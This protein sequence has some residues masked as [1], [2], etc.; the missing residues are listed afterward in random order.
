L[1]N[2]LVYTD[3]SG[4]IIF[5]LLAAAFCP[6]L[7]PYAI[8]LDYSWM[9]GGNRAVMKGESFGSGAWKGL[10]VGLA[11]NVLAPIGGPG[12]N[13]GKNLLLGTAEGTLI[14]GFDSFLWNKDVGNGMFWGGVEELCLLLLH[15]R[16]LKT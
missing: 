11:G 13:F 3:P 7:I 2:P 15:L 8:M 6:P 4:E 16:I 10:A 14:G 12:M 1:N 5:T 9:T